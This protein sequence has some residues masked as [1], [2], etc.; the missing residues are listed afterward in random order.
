MRLA[1]NREQVAHRSLYEDVSYEEEF[2]VP[3]P[4]TN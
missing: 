2:A 4:A 3:L 1:L